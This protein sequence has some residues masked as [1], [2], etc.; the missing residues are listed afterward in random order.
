MKPPD[1]VLRDHVRQWVAK[2]EVDYRT[3]ERLVNDSDP[4]RE[5][6]AFH[7]Q[8]AVEKYLKALLVSLQ[9]E[10]PKTH[11]LEELLDL[12]IPL[13]PDVA[14][15]LEGVKVLNPF[16]VK[17]RYPGDFPELL[18]GQEQTVFEVGKRTREAVRAQLG[19]HLADV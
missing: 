9:I 5:S 19:T 15:D 3:A 13:R 4:I 2:A 17:I 8:Q 10:F 12:L 14:A 7:C 6:I 16:G 11:D 18:P 1:A